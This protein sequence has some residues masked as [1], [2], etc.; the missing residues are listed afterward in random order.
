M[1]HSN[2]QRVLSY[3]VKTPNKLDDYTSTQII[4]IK[5]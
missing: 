4:S 3:H 2:L 5:S 1:T